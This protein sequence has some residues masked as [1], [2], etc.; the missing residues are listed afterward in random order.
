MIK[1]IVKN[2]KYLFS[3]A[4]SLK[5]MRLHP[6]S[7]KLLD[8]EQR[9]LDELNKYGVVAIPNFFSED[10]CKQMID[11]F[12]NLDDKYIKQYDNDKRIT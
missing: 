11:S 10:E 2:N 12:E 6:N 1:K 9:Y 7:S 4:L 5:E 3:L 8:D